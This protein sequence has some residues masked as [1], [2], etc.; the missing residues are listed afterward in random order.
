MAILMV[1]PSELAPG[2]EIV[3]TKKERYGSGGMARE[4]SR[5]VTEITEDGVRV[6]VPDNKEFES[7]VIPTDQV[8]TQWNLSDEK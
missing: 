8:H 4:I 5:T 6:Q 2:D 3:R 7:T 1:D